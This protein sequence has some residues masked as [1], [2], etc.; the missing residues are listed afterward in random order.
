MKFDH[1]EE[2]EQT[3][4]AHFKDA[5]SYSFESFKCSVYFLI[6]AIWPDTLE[7]KGSAKISKL[8][9]KIKNKYENILNS[10]QNL[11]NNNSNIKS[12]KII[13]SL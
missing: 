1:L 12:K 10:K 13:L 11:N 8:H 2:N 4:F 3:Y 6:H 5:I 9:E 7:K